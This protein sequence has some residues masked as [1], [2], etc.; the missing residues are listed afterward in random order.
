M[1]ATLRLHRSVGVVAAVG[2]LLW[3]LSGMI[4]PIMSRL[5]PQPANQTPPMQRISLAD[6][7]PIGQVLRQ[8]GVQRILNAHVVRLD[9]RD[10]YQVSVPD[11]AECLY[12]GIRDGKLQPGADQRYAEVLARY[13]LG[14][15]R[16]RVLEMALL[17]A[18]TDE[19]GFFNRYLPVYRARFDRPDGMRVYVATDGGRLGTLVNNAKGGLSFFFSN[20]HTWSF[21]KLH[22]AWK[23]PMLIFLLAAGISAVTGLRLYF[24]LGKN[25]RERLKRQPVRRFHRLLGLVVSLTTLTF[26]LSGGYHLV[27]YTFR[28]EPHPEFNPILQTA[29]LKDALPARLVRA[30]LTSLGLAKVGDAIYYQLTSSPSSPT[31]VSTESSTVEYVHALSGQ[32]LDQGDSVFARMLASFYS[33]LPSARIRS[34]SRITE[35]NDEYGFIFKRLPV[36]RIAYDTPEQDVYFVDTLGGRLAAHLTSADGQEG[37][38]FSQ[39]HKWMFVRSRDLRDLLT[40]LFAFGNAA[41]ALTGLWLLR[42]VRRRP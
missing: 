22:P 25:A 3:G 7:M 42:P 8:A 13:Y 40:L 15:T 23:L 18:H 21:L 32:A 19:Y 27:Y 9:G 38:T 11:R 28:P 6:A 33:G 16:S 26:T 36:F 37:W 10:Y 35:F 20:V 12:F 4:H 24:G 14:D 39:I 30:P 1:K 31:G 17:R 29:G 34:L 5:Q 2:L 41:I